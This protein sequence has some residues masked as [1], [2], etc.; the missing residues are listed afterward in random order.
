LFD[1]N[2]TSHEAGVKRKV[3]NKTEDGTDQM[4]GLWGIRMKTI[5]AGVSHNGTY[6]AHV[7]TAGFFLRLLRATKVGNGWKAPLT[8]DRRDHVGCIPV[9][10]NTANRSK[11]EWAGGIGVRGFQQDQVR[12]SDTS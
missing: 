2:T 4:G 7:L 8:V 6:P 1:I 5:A 9:G 11:R 12:G 3:D 10:V